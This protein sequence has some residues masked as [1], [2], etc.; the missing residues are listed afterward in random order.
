MFKK[1]TSLKILPV[2]ILLRDGDEFILKCPHCGH[3]RG[4]THNTGMLGE[5]KGEQYQDNL[6]NG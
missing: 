2:T 4:I 1:T 3:N 6:C 5:V